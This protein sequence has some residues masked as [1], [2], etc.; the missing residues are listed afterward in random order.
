MVDAER[1]ELQ[2]GTGLVEIFC[3][4]IN[5]PTQGV[6][7]PASG[8]GILLVGTLRA[9]PL[10]IQAQFPFGAPFLSEQRMGYCLL[11]ESQARPYRLGWFE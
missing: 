5:G 2:A 7:T 8:R 4:S 9:A 3:L 6:G 10:Q 11:V 1:S